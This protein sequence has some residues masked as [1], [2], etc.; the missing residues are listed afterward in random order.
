M[1]KA[2][3]AMETDIRLVDL[4]IE[5]LDA[6]LPVSSRNP[7]IDSI[8]RQKDR[9]IILNKKDL[10]DEAVTALWL[11][12][13]SRS[14]IQ[15]VPM[16]ARSRSSL[17]SVK[18]AIAKAE[19]DRMERNRKRGIL[20]RPVRA[21]V[22]GIPNVGKSTFINMLAGKSAAKTG[23]KPGVTRGN[24]WISLRSN[25]ELLDT[26]GLL[27]PK[28]EDPAVGVRLA[29]VGS[30]SDTVID[31]E[32]LALRGIRFMTASYPGRLAEKYGLAEQAEAPAVLTDIAVSRGCL[33]KGSQPDTA[34][35]ARLFLDDLRRGALGRLSLE[36]PP[37]PDAEVGR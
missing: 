5:I 33:L 31:P 22:A 34:R 15:A 1:T 2:R 13:F 4:V 14:G 24:Q 6:R 23:N 37:V 30:L 29:L 3:R 32:E 35:A 7:D 36:K 28:F 25:L 19:A 8:S 12:Y 16:D 17:R 26:P 20:N 27:W 21:L 18:D 11:D 9:L 10:A